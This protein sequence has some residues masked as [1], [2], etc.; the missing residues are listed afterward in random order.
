V[1][2]HELKCWPEPF[3]ALREGLKTYEIRSTADRHFSIGDILYLRE[4]NPDCSAESAYTGH[5]ELRVVVYMTSGSKWGLPP[6][7]CVMGLRPVV[8][9]VPK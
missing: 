4:W 7:L 3:R 8:A 2:I 5:A 6:Q 1:R 9:E